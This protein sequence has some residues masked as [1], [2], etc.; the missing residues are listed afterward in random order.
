MIQGSVMNFISDQ[1]SA[2]LCPCRPGFSSVRLQRYV[3]Q[4]SH[5]DRLVNSRVNYNL[6]RH[7]CRSVVNAIDNSRREKDVE[8]QEYATSA[9]TEETVWKRLLLNLAK[10]AAVAVLAAGLVSVTSNNLRKVVF[11][12]GEPHTRCRHCP[13]WFASCAHADLIFVSIVE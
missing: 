2:I 12:S 5:M 11:Y 13:G 8:V 6:K 9:P 1:K 4:I 7:S 3:H 10:T